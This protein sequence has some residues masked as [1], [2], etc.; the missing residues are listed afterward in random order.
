MKTLPAPL[1]AV[2]DQQ[3]G[4]EPVM[5]AEITWSDG[6][7]SKYSD[8][9]LPG[10]QHKILSIGSITNGVQTE[11][12]EFGQTSLVLDDTDSEI[13]SKIDTINIHESRCKINLSFVGVEESFTIFS[14]RIETPFSWDETGRQITFNITTQLESFEVGF[15]PEEGQLD[16]VSKEAVGKPWPLCFGGVRHVPAVKVHQVARA[17]LLDKFNVVDPLLY[18]KRNNLELAYQQQAFMFV[19]FDLIRQE[20]FNI[21]PSVKFTLQE[22][23][24]V[25]IETQVFQFRLM[26]LSRELNGIRDVLR[27]QPNDQPTLQLLRQRENDF[28]LLVRAGVALYNYL[29]Y[30]RALVP[31]IQSLYD[32]EKVITQ[33]MIQVYN[34]MR[35]LFADFL[36]VSKQICL[37]E[38]ATS[39]TVRVEG[40]QEFPDAVPVEVCIKGVKFLVQFNHDLGTMTLLG[41]P[42]D[43]YNNLP[44][45]PWV[46]DDEPCMAITKYDGL[47]LF[48]LDMDSP[49]NL[50]GLFLLVKKRGS[51]PQDNWRHVIKVERQVGNKVYFTLVR[52]DQGQTDQGQTGLSIDSAVNQIINP[53]GGWA[54]LGPFGTQIPREMFTGGLDS[55]VWALPEG[56]L[57]ISI[58]KLFPFGVSKEDLEYIAR[59]VMLLKFDDMANLAITNPGPRD[60]FTIVGEDVES[61]IA[62]NGLFPV[63]WTDTWKIP[64][65][66]IPETLG[67]DADI[68][69]EIRLCDDTCEVYVA[70]LLPSTIKSVKAYRKLPNGSRVLVDIPSR[71]YVKNEAQDMTTYTI[72]SLTFKRPITDM[73]GEEWEDNIY[74]TLD[75]S[76]GPNV[77]DV[78]EWLI[79]TYTEYTI[80][81]SNF[82]DIATKLENYPVNFAL[83][84]RPNVLQ[85][86]ARICYESRLGIYLTPE[87]V[88]RLVYLAEQPNNDFDF[89]ETNTEREGLQLNYTGTESI[90][91]RLT[92]QYQQDYL[93]LVPGA[94]PLKVV[95]RNNIKRYG[96]KPQDVTFHTLVDESTV[97]KTGTFWLIRKSNTWIQVELKVYQEA[98]VLDL[99]DGVGLEYIY[100]SDEQVIGRVLKYNYEPIAHTLTLT[101]ETPIRAGERTAFELFY[102]KDSAV[103]WPV[104]EEYAGGFG[105]GAGVSGTFEDCEV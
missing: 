99:L 98:L 7:V 55:T 25:V 58:L 72:T 42:S 19:M 56:Q 86:I 92:C 15:S 70:N 96:L 9:K 81:F 45:A 32:Q 11:A 73:A 60:I 51:N 77:T 59:L 46:P 16:F 75:S 47:D 67:F 29:A 22:Y 38:Q 88:F 93:P 43:V 27:R 71:Y 100:L 63:G 37:Q 68:G 90:I 14:G 94:E 6:S 105:P 36:E 80:D 97:I 95:L 39:L 3:Y 50:V 69:S 20:I 104:E 79:E 91:T 83:F 40:Y 4:S 53:P 1:Q 52:W 41:G 2:L 57:L 85:E 31:E 103:E 54:A 24:R 13:K 64:V 82:V 87:G 66:E 74:V 84:D 101:L 61:I 5:F 34:E 78:L 35:R 65:E 18:I 62:V 33:Q 21:K 10:Y 30:L 23:C 44:V 28:F 102:P 89:D 76:I 8:K 26:Q 17:T 48:Y 49:P 12:I